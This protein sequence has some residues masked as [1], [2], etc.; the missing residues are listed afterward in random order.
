[1]LS[2]VC[3]CKQVQTWKVHVLRIDA[4][5]LLMI[6]FNM[7]MGMSPTFGMILHVFEG[8]ISI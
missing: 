4:V 7:V 3:T 8:Y 6:I 2:H 1:M 5:G